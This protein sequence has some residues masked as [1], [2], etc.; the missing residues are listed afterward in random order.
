MRWARKKI[1]V[2]SF[3]VVGIGLGSVLLGL[4]IFNASKPPVVENPI[5]F[6]QAVFLAPD[7]SDSNSGTQDL[8]VQSITQGYAIAQSLGKKYLLFSVG[9]YDLVTTLQLQ[10]GISL[11][12]GYDQN[13]NWV[14]S[15]DNE[16]VLNISAPLAMLAD[17]IV[18]STVLGHLTIRGGNASTL[19]ESAYGIF[20]N[21]SNGLK[22]RH[23]HI[24]AGKGADGSAGTTVGG[25]AAS[26]GDGSAG[27]PGCEDSSGFCGACNQPQ[28]GSGG[29]A[30]HGRNG[31]KGGNAGRDGDNGIAGSAGVGDAAGG[32][33]TPKGQGNWNTPVDYSGITG[34]DGADGTNGAG[35]TISADSFTSAGVTPASGASG[36]TGSPGNGGGGGGGGGGGETEC[37]S[38]GG[39]G[40]GGGAGGFGGQAGGGGG[41]GG[42][43][44]A[45]YL[46]DSNVEITNSSLVTTGGGLGGDGGTGQEG[47]TGGQ[48]GHGVLANAGNSYG[49]SDEQDDGS[50][51]GRGGNGG[52]GG[53][54]GHGGGGP[55]GCSVGVLLGG[56]SN[57]QLTSISYQLGDAGAGGTSLGNNGPS[58]IQS[59][60]Y[61]PG[62]AGKWMLFNFLTWG[63]IF[64]L[65][66]VDFRKKRN[67]AC[68]P[69]PI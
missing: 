51:G 3:A 30:S 17:H 49:G 47:G 44:F 18:A 45:I 69:S 50:N 41:Y 28:G 38:Y 53:T 42:S 29:T 48:G 26:G 20:I 63:I 65:V 66:F 62:E 15:W 5:D 1:L 27:Q 59:N 6:A 10:A 57:P 13:S 31:G 22:I 56:T 64:G 36:T 35:G 12:G 67:L 16:V 46:W 25:T 23:C 58:G 33:G 19:S 24:M 54:G 7:G 40:G 43:S 37:N 60:T 32:P 11:Y 2:V 4:A 39:G 68:L 61:V 9:T 34:T 8:P 55:G 52:K 14:F 21:A